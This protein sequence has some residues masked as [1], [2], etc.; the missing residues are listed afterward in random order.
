FELDK[1]AL[2]VLVDFVEN[3]RRVNDDFFDDDLVTAAVFEVHARADILQG[4]RIGGGVAVRVGDGQSAD[5]RR[6][7]P[8]LNPYVVD[9]DSGLG[10]LRAVFFDRGRHQ[11]IQVG[12]KIVNPRGSR[13]DDNNDNTQYGFFHART[14]SVVTTGKI[15]LLHVFV[16]TYVFRVGDTI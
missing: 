12:I 6:T 16:M 15:A 5:S 7:F 9:P 4:E 11:R 3:F 13:E 8:G 1:V 2:P 10:D 14:L